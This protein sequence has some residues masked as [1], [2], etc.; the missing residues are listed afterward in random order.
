[1]EL[2]DRLGLSPRI[3]ILAWIFV[4]LL[5]G[6]SGVF[7][8]LLSSYLLTFGGRDEASKHG[9]SEVVATRVGGVVVVSY[10]AFFLSYQ[11]QLGR[12]VIPEQGW[13][14]LVPA[15]AFFIVGLYEDL[16]ASL[17][18]RWRFI[19]M[20]LIALLALLWFPKMNLKEVGIPLLDVL[21]SYELVAFLFTAACLAF[22]PNAFNTADGANG[23]I[24]G[25]SIV[26][27]YG[28]SHA[29][30][31]EALLYLN[32]VIVGCA[33]LLVFNLASGRFFL[34][35][36]GAYFLGAF[37]G[38][39]LILCSNTTDAS[40]WWMLSLVFYPIAD[41]LWSMARRALTNR[42]PMEPD[43]HHLHN[44]VNAII[45]G[46][47]RS[48]YWANTSTGMGI[49]FCFGGIPLALQLGASIPLDSAIWGAV[50]VVQWGAYALLWLFLNK[51]VCAIQ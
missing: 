36:G 21:L 48:D 24:S 17:S 15:T 32:T 45:K 19:L 43:N 38:V 41:L 29:M 8:M 37:C 2:T 34:G 13:M 7:A 44:L 40:T 14:V 22:I 50:V 51:R 1:M 25:T 18:S 31:M 33:V 46:N 12:L 3:A 28:L 9:I 6:L 11:Y 23:L 30:P 42:S 35:D 26:A 4:V 47:G 49:V 5:G 10:T 27:L 16:K 39:T 20:S